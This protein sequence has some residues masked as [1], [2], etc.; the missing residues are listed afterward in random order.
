MAD[1]GVGGRGEGWGKCGNC[2][3]EGWK[4]RGKGEGR[5]EYRCRVDRIGRIHVSG[6]FVVSAIKKGPRRLCVPLLKQ[7]YQSVTRAVVLNT[8]SRAGFSS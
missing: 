6:G 5:D 2:G 4:R 1:E 8:D 7:A 3:V